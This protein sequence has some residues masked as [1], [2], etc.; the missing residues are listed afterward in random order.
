MSTTPQRLAANRANAQLSAGPTTAAGKA[1]SSRNATRHGLLGSRL[2][3]DDEDGAEFDSL[4]AD[5]ARTL[6]PADAIEEALVARIAV[7][8]WR[9]RRL[10]TAETAA[11]SLAR[12]TRKIARRVDDE[13]S[14]GFGRDVTPEELQPF[15]A[16]QEQWCRMVIAEIEALDTPSLVTIEQ[17]A[18]LLWQQLCSDAE[19][20]DGLNNAALYIAKF[21]GGLD[22][23]LAELLSWCRGQ[24]RE[25]EARPHLLALTEHVRAKCLV[26]P[27][28]TLEVLA[29]YQTTLD[30]QLYKALRALRDAQAWRLRTLEATADPDPA[31]VSAEPL[32]EA[33]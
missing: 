31:A 2:L 23:Y 16:E 10:E 11:I 27:T 13:L 21:D 1:V 33:A 29:R 4:C 30:N 20:G 3:L 12:Q 6:T 5:L 14:R 8:L 18:P 24:I 7:A 9:Q 22:A 28:D 26:L 25:A 32:V 19:E 17:R 15:N